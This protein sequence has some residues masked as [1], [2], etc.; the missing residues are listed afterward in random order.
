MF[1]DDIVKDL[2]TGNCDPVRVVDL[3]VN[4][5][6]YADDIVLLSE[7]KSGL[8]SS[9]NILGTYCSNG[10]LQVNVEKSKVLIF[11]SKGKTHVNEFSYNNNIIQ[12]VSKYCY[13]G[14]ML[15]FL[16]DFWPC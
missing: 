9:L 6:L 12:A 3:S 14:V 10:K 16:K 7:S 5:L 8:Q 11:N 2:V 4:C 15:K 1:I 13:L